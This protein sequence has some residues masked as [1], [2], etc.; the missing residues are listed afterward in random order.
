M[1]GENWN[2]SK[3]EET[4]TKLPPIKDKQSKDDLYLAIEKGSKEEIRSRFTSKARRPW[5]IPAIATAAAI[6]LIMLII[7]PFFSEDQQFSTEDA[8]DR[9][10][11]EIAL[12]NNDSENVDDSR[13]TGIE[14]NESSITENEQL[15]EANSNES[16]TV[17]NNSQENDAVKENQIPSQLNEVMYTATVHSVALDGGNTDFIV[18]GK[19]EISQESRLEDV[20]ITALQ[21][22]DPTSGQYLSDLE[23]VSTE[24]DVVV[25]DF[26]NS[27]SLQSLASTEQGYLVSVFEELFSLYGFEEIAFEAD[28]ESGIAFGQIGDDEE[29]LSI[30]SINRG[31]YLIESEEEFFLISARMAGENI[32]NEETGTP[33]NFADTIAKM[34]EPNKSVDWYESAIPDSIDISDVRIP[35]TTA[36]VYYTISEEGLLNEEQLE[37]FFHALKLSAIPF[38]LENLLIINEQ[39][40]EVIEVDLSSE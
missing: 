20:L 7:P 11:L 12:F 34:A 24:E 5:I 33:L 31:Y 9:K 6:F 17:E 2:D 4:L 26:A 8:A 40:G 10:D 1:S 15:D 22:S 27:R 14:H 30:S 13:E 32:A 39:S 36:E 38:T 28:G 29:S 21:E 19:K 3:I 18:I 35:G 37:T 23:E 16:V 25:L